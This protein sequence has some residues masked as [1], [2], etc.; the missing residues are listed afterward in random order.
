MTKVVHLSSAHSLGDTRIFHKELQSLAEQGFDCHYVAFDDGTTKVQDKVTLHPLGDRDSKLDRWADLP[1]LYAAA[2]A[3]GADV[4]HLHDWDLLP[5][6]LALKRR[7]S[8]QV[9]YDVHEDYPHLIRNRGW[10]PKCV[11]PIVG[12]TFPR[13]EAVASNYFDG[14]IAATEWVEDSLRNRGVTE[15]T[16]IHNY[17]KTSDINVSNA[18]KASNNHSYTLA[19]TGGLSEIRGLFDMIYLLA[20][21]RDQGY[22]VSLL[23]LGQFVSEQIEK[24]ARSLITDLGIADAVDFPGYVDYQQMFKYLTAADIGLALLDVEHYKGG[25]PT[26]LF[27]YMYSE[28]PVVISNIQATEKYV[29]PEWGRVVPKSNT[30]EQVKTVV[31]LFEN[32]DECAAMG[33]AGRAAVEAEFSWEEEHKELIRLYNRLTT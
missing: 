16:T 32:P 12:A 11:Q 22:D 13:F 10:I 8:G 19:Y 33:E 30:K 23:C 6:G 28:L 1:E 3:I 26:K 18:E 20:E 5:V 15:V 31:E 17:P 4:Y 14:I 29:T 24:D 27:E 21:L 2:S 7:T 25:I 9:I